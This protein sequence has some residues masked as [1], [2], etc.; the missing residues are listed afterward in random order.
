VPS[1]TRGRRDDRQSAGC[2]T[3]RPAACR[4]SSLERHSRRGGGQDAARPG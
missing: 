2:R 3:R 4:R 1:R